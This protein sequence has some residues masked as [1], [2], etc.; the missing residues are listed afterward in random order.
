MTHCRLIPHTS[1]ASTSRVGVWTRLVLGGFFGRERFFNGHIAEL[2][3][4]EDFSA[5]FTLNEF[6]VF[7]ARDYSDAWV[8]TEWLHVFS[9]GSMR[10]WREQT[11][12][13]DSYPEIPEVVTAA[14]F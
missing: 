4:L 13:V 2:A 10:G 8:L 9:Q 7:I 5:E 3:C 11:L 6:G 14:R 12:G 1:A